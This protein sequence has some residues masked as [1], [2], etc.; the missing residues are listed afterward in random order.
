[1]INGVGAPQSQQNSQL[2][3]NAGNFRQG[4]NQKFAG[5]TTTTSS[6]LITP[7][8]VTYNQNSGNYTEKGNFNQNSGNLQ[9]SGTFNQSSG[10][11]NASTFN[12][13]SPNFVQSTMSQNFMNQGPKFTNQAE[14][15]FANQ[16]QK[17]I[18]AG[19]NYGNLGQNVVNQAVGTQQ[20]PQQNQTNSQYSQGTFRQGPLGQNFNQSGSIP[21]QKTQN[22]TNNQFTPNAGN[23]NQNANKFGPNASGQTWGNQPTGVQ[24]QPSQNPPYNNQSSTSFNQ[25]PIGQNF[26]NPAACIQQTQQK[27]NST[28]TQLNQNALAWLNQNFG[29]N[30]GGGSSGT[31]SGGNN[32]SGV[33]SNPAGMG[34]IT[35]ANMGPR[36]P[37]GAATP[38]FQNSFT[39]TSVP[40]PPN[41]QGAA[42]PS[43]SP[44]AMGAGYM[45]TQW[46]RPPVPPVSIPNMGMM[47]SPPPPPPPPPQPGNHVPSH[48]QPMNQPPLPPSSLSHPPPP[49]SMKGY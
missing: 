27:V 28:N 39:P 31:T 36:G 24:Q 25:G 23:F 13:S 1:M 11:K 17:F 44:H 20:K 6:D 49:P 48:S 33:G 38:S 40:P 46:Q 45:Q 8:N 26:P 37:T 12:Q 30:K 21:P 34:G 10:I 3:Q 7:S 41:M 29:G 5:H 47:L 35:G 14:P 22:Q 2:N 4:T 18:T 15:N 32:P 42:F 43:I 16:G 9:N 19:Q